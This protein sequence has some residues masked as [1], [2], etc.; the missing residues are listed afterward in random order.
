MTNAY[1]KI[2]VG[3]KEIG[4]SSLLLYHSS[5]SQIC[6]NFTS[7]LTNDSYQNCQFHR[8]IPGFMAQSG[9]FT[10][11]DGTS[12]E[13]IYGGKFADVGFV[14]GHDGRGVLSMANCGEDTNGS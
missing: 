1:M 14:K 9:D 6:H 10:D 8:I 12:G 11:H 7:L 13:S 3:G 2:S 5:L 4:Y